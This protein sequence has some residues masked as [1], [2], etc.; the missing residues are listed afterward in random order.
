MEDSLKMSRSFIKIAAVPFACFA[1]AALLLS[2]CGGGGSGGSGG[3][4]ANGI[5]TSV[6]FIG[7]TPGPG[8]GTNPTVP[9][10]TVFRDQTLEF[11]FDGN[12][13]NGV[14]GGFVS[15]GGVLT[16]LQYAES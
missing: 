9:L 11:T 2:G 12:L 4:N 1:V 3:G 13:D 8:V 5:L 15:S 6:S 14:F 16:E 10:P 7:F